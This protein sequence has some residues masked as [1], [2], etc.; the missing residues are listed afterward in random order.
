[1]SRYS[2]SIVLLFSFLLTACTGSPQIEVVATG[3]NQPRG[4]SFDAAGNLYVAEAG[5]V[6][7]E[8]NSTITPKTMASVVRNVRNLRP[9]R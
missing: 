6:D 2:F 7:P 3:L 1:M 5:A 9:D 8:D 4:L